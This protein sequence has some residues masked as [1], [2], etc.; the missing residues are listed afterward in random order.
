MFSFY[1]FHFLTD[2]CGNKKCDNSQKE[3]S[4]RFSQQ[5]PPESVLGRS[6]CGSHRLSSSPDLRII[7]FAWPSQ[8]SPMTDFR[9]MQSLHAYSGG[10]VRELHT[11][12]YSSAGLLPL[13]RHSNGY[14]LTY[15]IAPKKKFV[16]QHKG[17]KF[18]IFCVMITQMAF[19]YIIV[20]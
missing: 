13:C 17:L 2:L 4:H 19:A 9:L 3:L 12:L 5:R 15:S 6:R 14:L 8:V 18:E 20:R 11:I 10:T 16:N 7:G 1:A